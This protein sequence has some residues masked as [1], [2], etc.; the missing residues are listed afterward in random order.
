MILALALLGGAV[1]TRS[2]AL[3]QTAPVAVLDRID[4][5]RWLDSW[6][7]RAIQENDLPG[8]VIAIVKDT[9]VL[10]AKGYGYADLA[11]RTPMDP[12]RTVIR[13]ASISK[14][15]TAVSVLQQVEQGKLELDRDVN[16]YLDFRIPA[17][18]GRPITL[19]SLLTH[20]AGFAEISYRKWSP[21]RSLRDHVMA[22]PERIDPPGEVTAYSNYGVELAGYIVSR[23]SGEPF[24]QY[25]ERHVLQALG[26][27]RSAFRMTLP[28]AL[29]AMAVRNYGTA[30]RAD[31]VADDL[32]AALAPVGAPSA[33]LATTAADMTRFLLAELHGGQWEG[34]RIL[35]DETVRLM[36]APA[37]TPIAGALPVS[38][39]LFRADYRG[40]RVIGHEGDGEGTHSGFNLLPDDGIGIF[41][42]MNGDGAV[43]GMFPG[44]FGLRAA[45]FERLIDR[46]LPSPAAPDEPTVIT[47]KSHAQLVAGEYEWS[48]RAVGDYQEAFALVTRYLAFKPWIK[49]NPDGT[50]ETPASLTFAV[51]GRTR[52]WREVGPFRWRDVA[53]PGH[54]VMKMEND[55]VR[56]LWSD[57]A[58]SVWVDLPVS[59]IRSSR[60]NV[61]LLGLSAAILVLATISWPFTVF[62]AR[63]SR[64]SDSS[65]L[66]QWV[67]LATVL[68]VGYLAAWLMVMAVDLSSQVGAE[69]WIRAIQALGLLLVVGAGAAIVDAIAAWR[70][71]VALGTRLGRTA[72]AFGL[73]YLV[74]FCF[75]FHL[76]S[77]RIH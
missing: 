51:D 10:L 40:H 12:E 60:L 39:G 20:S 11:A 3:G 76:I 61:P 69:P 68:G 24:E 5:E 30:S 55:R 6:V 70:K 41:V 38:L 27:D 36:Q 13:A 28:P 45:I 33:A 49:A 77:A 50:I 2:P 7:P 16:D 9:S 57:Q 35:R 8:L 54:L 15:F 67:R 66:A 31:P 74:W 18:F 26:M 64:R 17:A 46:Y 48:R 59:T 53:G 19:R 21:P 29:A 34:H 1:V 71:D 14:S 43:R 65:R 73:G 52:T 58:P 32:F 56:S 75:L 37:F 22:V 4:L 47:A 23:V 72:V 25:V 42:A 63:R 62:L 44:A